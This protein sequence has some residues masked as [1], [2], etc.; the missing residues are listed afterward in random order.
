MYDQMPRVVEPNALSRSM[1]PALLRHPA[2]SGEAA[3]RA[4]NVSSELAPHAHSGTVVIRLLDRAARTLHSDRAAAAQYIA[5]ATALLQ[6]EQDWA[7]HKGCDPAAQISRGGLAPWQIR[8]VSDYVSETLASR[9][10]TSDCAR[11]ARLSVSHFSRAFK[12]SFGETLSR[13]IVRR[14]VE[15]AQ[16]MIVLTNAPLCQVALDCGFAD[17]SHFSRL[18]SRVVGSSPAAWRRQWHTRTEES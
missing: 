11:L 10:H 15:R 17:Q 8:K 4:T 3:T 13:Y 1:P 14:R 16:E 2:F 7:N 5:R 18:F 6:A 9:I 12:L